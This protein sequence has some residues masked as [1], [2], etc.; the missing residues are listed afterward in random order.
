[1]SG[2]AKETRD[3]VSRGAPGTMSDRNTAVDFLENLA[4]RSFINF[5]LLL[6]FKWRVPLSGWFF[7]RIISPLAGYNRRIQDNL[8]LVMPDLSEAEVRKL[9]RSVPDNFGRALIETYSGLKF[10]ALFKDAPILGPGADDL[11]EAAKNGRPVILV[12]G[13][14][15]NYEAFRSTLI[16]RGYP[17]AALYREMS[18]PFFHKHYIAAM[19]TISKPIFPR[20]RAGFR[21]MVGWLKKGGMLAMIIDQHMDGAAKLTFMGQPAMTALSAAELALKYDALLLPIYGIRKDD[22]LSFDVFADTPVAHSEAEKMTQELNDS[23]EKVVHKHMDQWFWIHRR[24]KP[25]RQSSFVAA[26]TGPTD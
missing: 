8:R 18:N 6:P 21:G 15:G 17:M 1:M 7:S 19:E 3:L 12:S 5:A 9:E 24:W 23:L 20:G 11:E 25:D 10:R 16:E 26:N 22:G 14:F 4:V 2:N 13:H